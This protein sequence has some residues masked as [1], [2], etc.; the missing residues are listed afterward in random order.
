MNLTPAKLL[1]LTVSCLL[2]GCVVAAATD[3]AA[4][5]VMTV[6]KV[7]VK[8]TSAVVRAAI[9]DGD[10]KDSKKS[11]KEKQKQQPETDYCAE[12]YRPAE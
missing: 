3:L 5:T 7:A 9:P 12:D 11:K 4:S 6:G 1:A 8:G 10:D 2:N